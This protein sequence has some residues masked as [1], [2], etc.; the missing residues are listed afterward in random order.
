MKL[1]TFVRVSTDFIELNATNKMRERIT[2]VRRTSY[3][4]YRFFTVLLILGLFTSSPIFAQPAND[5]CNSD[6]TAPV[7]GS[8]VN[9]FIDA[10]TTVDVG[11]G[12]CVGSGAGA[13]NVWF[14]F[15]AQGS[16]YDIN[17]NGLGGTGEITLIQFVGAPCD[18]GSAQQIDCGQL[19]VVG[20]NTLMAGAQYY[21]IVTSSN[22]TN[23][24]FSLCVDNPV[25]PPAPPNDDPC[26]PE[27]APVDGSCVTG[28]TLNATG[29]WS[30]PNCPAQ[31]EVSVWYSATIGPS[32]NSL[33]V[34]IGNQTISGDISVMVGTFATDCT[35]GFTIAGQY[36]GPG[37]MFSATGLTPGSTVFVVVSSADAE[38]GIFD[39][40]LT[41]NGPPPACAAIDECAGAQDISAAAGQ[42]TCVT[43][44]N[45]G[46]A[47]DPTGGGGCFDFGSIPT[48]WY[49]FTADGNTDFVNIDLNSPQFDLPQVAVFQ[50]DCT[51]G[52]APIDCSQGAAGSA[53]LLQ[54]DVT[55]TLTYYIAV[56]SIGGQDGEFNICLTAVPSGGTNCNASTAFNVVNTSMGSPPSGPFQAGEEVEICI[57]VTYSSA[58]NNCQWIHG[59]VPEFGDCW[60]DIS[61]NPDGSPV[62]ASTPGGATWNWYSDGDVTYNDVAGGP[63]GFGDP[64]GAGWF[65]TGVA[66]NPV[67]AWCNPGDQNID[68]NCSW[69]VPMGCGTQQNFVFCVTLTT[70]MYPECDASP[71]NINCGIQIRTFGDGETGGWV[72]TG[73]QL[74]VPWFANYSLNCC[75]PPTMLPLPLT[76]C[77]DEQLDIFLDDFIQPAP[78]PGDITYTWT[79]NAPAG[80]NGASPCGGGCGN[81]LS[82]ILENTT[83]SPQQV[84]YTITPRTLGGCLGFP[85]DL[86]ITVLPSVVPMITNP[87]G[88][89]CSGADATLF[90][91][92]TGGIAPYN[93]EW[94]TGDVGISTTITP[95]FTTAY[96]LTVTDGNGCTGETEILVEANPNLVVTVVA[97]PDI[98]EICQSDP[99]F[100]IILTAFADIG[101]PGWLYNWDLP[102]GAQPSIPFVQATQT[103]TYYVTLQDANGCT[104]ESSLDVIVHPPANIVLFPVGPL[105]QGGT[106]VVLTAIQDQPG[107]PGEWSGDNVSIDGIFTPTTAGTS[108]VCYDFVSDAGCAAQECMDIVVNPVPLAPTF[109]FFDSDVCEN[110]TGIMYCVDV[111]AS[112]DSYTWTFPAGVIV[113]AGAGTTCVTVDW[114]GAPAGDVCV[115]ASNNCGD[116]LEICQAVAVDGPS[117]PPSG[118][119]GPLAPCQ[120]ATNIGYSINPVTGATSYTWTATNGTITGSGTSV[121]VDWG[122]GVGGEICVTATSD[123]GTSA[124]ACLPVT[125]STPPA[126]PSAPT[127]PTACQNETGV[128]YSITDVAGA[129]GYTWS[130]PNGTIVSGQG[131]TSITVDWGT[132]NGDVCV[133]ADNDCGSSA[134]ACLPVVLEQ[135]PA[136]PGPINGLPILCQNTNGETYSIGVPNG[137]TGYTWTVPTNVTIVSGDGTNE[138]TVD[139]GIFAMGDICVTPFNDCGDASQ[140][141]FTIEPLLVPLMPTQLNDASA[142]AGTTGLSYTASANGATDY[143]W[144]LP[145]GVSMVTGLNSAT[146]GFNTGTLT[147]GT[148]PVCVTPSNNCG[149]GPQMCFDLTIDDV[150]GM[151]STSSIDDNICETTTDANY[152]IN[153]VPNADGYTWTVPAGAT[154]VTGINST[155]ITVNWNGVL[156]GQICVLAYNDCGDGPSECFNVTADQVLE[157]PTVQCDLNNTGLDQVGF[158]VSHPSATDFSYTWTINGGPVQGPSSAMPP[159]ITGLS[160]NDEVELFVV[161]LANGNLCG[162]SAPGSGIC[163]ANDCV[164]DPPSIQG[165]GAQF[166]LDSAP[167]QFDAMPAGGT[168]SGNG[169]SA[170]GM[171]DPATAG[172]GPVILTYSLIDANNCPQSGTITIEVNEFPTANAGAPGLLS[173]AATS[174]QLD[175]GNSSTGGDFSYSWSGP[176]G[177]TIVDGTTLTPTVDALGTYTL[178]VT[179]TVTTCSATSQ[180]DVD[181][182][183]N[184][185]TASA[186][187]DQTI[188]CND[189][190]V[191]LSGSAMNGTNLLY[192]WAGP[193]IT[194]ANINEINPVVSVPGAYSLIVTNQSNGCESSPASVDVFDS[195]DPVAEAGMGGTYACSTNGL[196]LDG[197]GSETGMNISYLWT[198]PGNITD[199]NTLTPTVDAA[200]TYT[201]L[202]TNTATGCFASDDVIIAPDNNAPTAIV[203]PTLFLTCDNPM[204]ALSGSSTAMNSSYAWTGP[205]MFMSADPNPIVSEV[206]S[207]FLIVTD[208]TNGCSSG[209][210]E[211]V[212]TQAT[213]PVADAGQPAV[214]TCATTSLQ[215][216]GSGTPGPTIDYSW[217]GPGTII[218]GNTLTP[219]IDAA[220]EFTLTVT[221]MA[222]G[223]FATSSVTIDPDSNSPTAEAGANQAITC[224][225]LQ[226]TLNGNGL[227][228]SNFSY[229]WTG[230]GITP[231]NINDQNPTVNQAGQ[232]FL[233]VTNN[234][235]GCSSPGDPVDVTEPAP[236]LVNAGSSSILSC[237]QTSLQLDA[238]AGTSS[239]PGLQYLW[240]G[241]GV[242]DGG[243]TLEPT[244][245]TAGTFTLTVSNPA[246]GCSE[247]ADVTIDP[248]LNA[249]TAIS[250]GSVDFTCLTS[251]VQITVSTDATNPSYTWSGPGINGTNINLQSP[252]VDQPGIYSVLVENL[253]NGCDNGTNVTVVDL[254]ADPVVEAGATDEFACSDTSIDLDGAGSE[255]G[256]TI[257]YLWSGPGTITNGTTLT[258]SVDAAGTYELL[259]TNTATGCFAMD[260]VTITPDQDAPVAMVGAD[261][262][263]DCDND[264]SLQLTGNTTSTSTTLVYT[265]SGPGINAGNMN[266]QN[267]VVTVPGDYTLEIN[268]TSNG[269]T[270]NLEIQSITEASL[271][272]AS[273]SPDNDLTLNCLVSTAVLNYT[274]CTPGD[275]LATWMFNDVEIGTG[276]TITF[277]ANENSDLNGEV[278]LIVTNSVT[279]CEDRDTIQLID[280][281]IFPGALAGEDAAIDCE[282]PEVQLT[283]SSIQTG[284][285]VTYQWTGPNIIGN[286]NQEVITVGSQGEY[287]LTAFES[288]SGCESVDTAFVVDNSAFPQAAAEDGFLDCTYQALELTASSTTGGTDLDYEWFDNNGDLIAT[289]AQISTDSAGTYNVVITD[290]FNSCTDEITVT[291]FEPDN[292]PVSFDLISEDP[293]CADEANGFINVLSVTGGTQ[294]FEYTLNDVA[295][296]DAPIVTGLTPGTYELVAIDDLGCELSETIVI[297]NPA[298]TQVNVLDE[299]VLDWGDSTNVLATINFDPADIQEIIWSPA[300]AVECLNDPCTEVKILGDVSTRI[301]VTVITNDGCQAEDVL[302]LRV[303]KDFGVYFPTAFSPGG[304]G[305][306]DFFKP[307]FDI[308]KVEKIENFI[309][310]DRWGEIVYRQ[311][312]FDASNP[313][314]GWDGTLDNKLLNPAVFVY[315]ANVTFIDGSTREFAG[316]VTLMR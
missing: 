5:D 208:N 235:N 133:T 72:Q 262:M 152:T 159:V 32:S 71:D 247:S 101:G 246:T 269:C 281:Y 219:T 292:L 21:I 197:I 26:A 87:T 214:L 15:T 271:P 270:S 60:D 7:D 295:Y 110:A 34:V 185:P 294:P 314:G 29:D 183:S 73:C 49:T 97:N 265:W 1:T 91:S 249:P 187:S 23:G 51:G 251:N 195:A 310:V 181:P 239:E 136:N 79:V 311:A 280:E 178:T 189:P 151:P 132:A 70:K 205:N 164:N 242:I 193:G 112:A 115:Y 167:Q 201:L 234:D 39:L 147:A 36:C 150:P 76:A 211:V 55:A 182:D 202:V 4:M 113:T 59:L 258:P 177:A 47:P 165:D 131:S 217:S 275:E 169:I 90:G 206:G 285:T 173:C 307:F 62:I 148:Y 54:V 215:L 180:V 212:V 140:E 28:T 111:V 137:A 279:G 286:A 263:L 17:I 94:S 74:D 38:S 25:D 61:F 240:T 304:D 179:N 77:S 282:F 254:T 31:G 216:S 243:N 289:G 241:P 67:P 255:T 56:G 84:T 278:V 83:S 158:T 122:A 123:C 300:S 102:S 264:F 27:N 156:G 10:L 237:A 107:D 127:G 198:G 175:G 24:P 142:C 224:N 30:N 283:G 233:I 162:D 63:F 190:D 312:L 86:V 316:D 12:S 313:A 121:T 303:E 68:P 232:Y 267:P 268:D 88:A 231:A 143:T 96:Q 95:T 93:Y 252:T 13:P 64:V 139:L 244:V 141:C 210:E 222:T 223:C 186:G 114:N 199:E 160:P 118:L 6:T 171:F 248:D 116:G 209:G 85:S 203:V 130:V 157:P 161:A 288:D 168:W 78:N 22:G 256:A 276:C 41:E 229:E 44:C 291:V 172:V 298:P 18:F 259:V 14:S 218:D 166:C 119:T 174:V 220:G 296:S 194:P 253:D 274:G 145:P 227:N 2:H 57:D 11:N 43:G 302:D 154:I 272:V 226:V 213:D 109:T 125:F 20:T 315:Y 309:V 117:S 144:D 124:P 33:D 290:N 92:A 149:D 89:V 9:G 120:N 138:I 126:A 8:C 284:P 305:I 16:D 134:P 301:G 153:D 69:G 221:D 225:T 106:E 75:E 228:G 155:S 53:S 188:T 45:T 19:N 257:E 52:L 103:G 306:N 40:C 273:I 128:V 58:S 129:T 42:N 104:G 297:D 299:V 192:E 191:T 108:N 261:D 146:V 196:G 98:T 81:V 65:V 170:T 48:V 3:R 238:T 260:Q 35:S 266:M 176:A 80:V 184:A 236:I 50:G 200:G 277:E 250:G 82:T 163:S 204:L 135:V 37:G 99:Q 245:Y 293:R 105:C 66:P 100:P 207:Y 308:T 287:I 46:T 230:P